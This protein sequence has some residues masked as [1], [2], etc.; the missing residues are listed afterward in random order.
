MIDYFLSLVGIVFPFIALIF[1]SYFVYNWRQDKRE[2]LREAEEQRYITNKIIE[3][4]R[5]FS[6]NQKE[7]LENQKILLEKQLEA[8][9]KI[10][11]DTQQQQRKQEQ[12]IMEKSAGNGS[13]GYIFVDLPKEKRSIFMEL[14][15]GFEEFAQIKGYEV[16]FSFDS[17]FVD[18]IAF[19]FTQA[20]KET[21]VTTEEVQADFQ[22]YVERIQNGG[23]LD[24]LPVIL[25]LLEHNKLLT[26]MKNRINFLQH[27]YNLEKNAVIF[28][29]RMLSNFSSVK[30]L[31]APNV[32][33]HTGGN[34]T[35]KNYNATN[36]S[37]L[38]QGE[39]N[40]YTDNSIDAS[41]K[42]AGS[43]NEKKNQIE[44]IARLIEI[45]KSN[46]EVD[47]TEKG[48]AITNLEKVK[49]E[50][51]DEEKPDE[52]RIKKWLQKA[53]DSLALLKLG[54]EGVDAVVEVYKSLGLPDITT[55]NLS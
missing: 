23:V 31:P 40:D 10:W 30:L 6:M 42:I 19:K 38:I 29:E 2:R 33:V 15:K 17:T 8:Q 18:R 55:L 51:Q 16:Y 48:K 41:I 54:K 28:Y 46:N 43:F 9:R 1:F 44:S 34:M 14:L 37:H 32:I 50:L 25:S 11:V 21:N 13:G 24:D 35:S 45:L 7:D 52:S 53:K 36:S 27:N 22:E 3:E 39:N 49:D 26:I 5:D 20:N 12:F 47:A 4:Q